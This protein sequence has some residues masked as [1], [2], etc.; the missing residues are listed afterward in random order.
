[1][2][3]PAE[4]SGG[5]VGSKSGPGLEKVRETGVRVTTPPRVRGVDVAHHVIR[6]RNRLLDRRVALLLPLPPVVGLPYDTPLTP[7]LAVFNGDLVRVRLN[8]RSDHDAAESV[9]GD[10]KDS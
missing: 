4:V 8:C 7:P 1:L 9:A 5:V 3:V 2:I 6:E 10:E